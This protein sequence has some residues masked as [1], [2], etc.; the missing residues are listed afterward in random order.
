[1]L[2]DELAPFRSTAQPC[3]RE[4]LR[5]GLSRTL[6]DLGAPIHAAG[7]R[8]DF[9]PLAI[10]PYVHVPAPPQTPVAVPPVALDS[11]L[12]TIEQPQRVEK[13]LQFWIP[14]AV[15]GSPTVSA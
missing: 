3:I 5:R 8:L 1:M 13:S 2:R 10:S 11:H 4:D 6:L 15:G 14:Y 9:P 12:L 7:P